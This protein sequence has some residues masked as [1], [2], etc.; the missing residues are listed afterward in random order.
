MSGSRVIDVLVVGYL[1]MAAAVHLMPLVVF[2]AFLAG[3]R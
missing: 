3:V 2:A 1:A